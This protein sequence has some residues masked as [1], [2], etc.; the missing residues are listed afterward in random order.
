VVGMG[1]E[2]ENSFEKCFPL[3]MESTPPSFIL[4]QIPACAPKMNVE[5][6]DKVLNC[7][8]F[9]SVNSNSSNAVVE[10]ARHS[11]R[12][13]SISSISGSESLKSVDSDSILPQSQD[14]CGTF[15]QTASKKT[16]KTLASIILLENKVFVKEMEIDANSQISLA[17]VSLLH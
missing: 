12:R 17:N 15:S 2:K 9:S 10:F 1:N 14:T 5:N 7:S 13:Q 3:N 4:N 16:R 8:S 6:S 11:L